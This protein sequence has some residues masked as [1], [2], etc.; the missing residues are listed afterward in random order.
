MAENIKILA[1]RQDIVTIADAVR[2][3]TG[4]NVEMTLSEIAD[5]INNV[6]VATTPTILVSDSGLITATSGDKSATKQLSTQAAKTIT[7]STS[8]QTAVV[9]NVYTT[10]V[11][12]VEAIPSSYIQP[13]GTLDV[14]ANG[15]HDVKNYASVNVNVAGSSGGSGG[16]TETCSV[17][18]ITPP[19]VCVFGYGTCD[20]YVRID[21]INWIL[22]KSEHT[23]PSTEPNGH[24]V[25]YECKRVFNNVPIGAVF[26]FYILNDSIVG[27]TVSDAINFSLMNYQYGSMSEYNFAICQ[28]NG[29]GEIT[30]AIS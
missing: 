16:G 24:G 29:D 10:G 15:T 20:E 17:T 4:T 27:A 7:P 21:G 28:C 19:G 12:T 6:P 5:S 8:S 11:I 22:L 30:I 26:T 13:S 1:D 9:K 14:T 2:S 18:I 25:P 23:M 3:K